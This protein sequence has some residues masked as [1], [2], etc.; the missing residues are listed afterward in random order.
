MRNLQF[1]GPASLLTWPLLVWTYFL[2][3]VFCLNFFKVFLCVA[4][5]FGTHFKSALHANEIPKTPWVIDEHQILSPAVSAGITNVLAESARNRNVHVRVMVLRFASHEMAQIEAKRVVSEWE[6]RD[7]SLALNKTV[8]FIIHAARGESD[9]ILGKNLQN[10]ASFHE[11]THRVKQGIIQPILAT[12]NIEKAATEGAIALVTVL[13]ELPV[14]QGPSVLTLTADWLQGYYLL[15][16]LKLLSA[17]LLIAGIWF[18]LRQY[19]KRPEWEDVSQD[20][21]PVFD[22]LSLEEKNAT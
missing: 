3:R 5:T 10:N 12:G 21:Q 19:L 18:T 14:K 2:G 11:N 1:E 8:Y 16:P 15:M 9:I 6:N 20:N 4:L 7:P 17:F 22:H 13:E